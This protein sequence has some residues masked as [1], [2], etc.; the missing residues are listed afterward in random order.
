MDEFIDAL[1]PILICLPL[2]QFSITLPSASSSSTATSIDHSDIYYIIV[3]NSLELIRL[4]YQSKIL[5]MISIAARCTLLLI[6]L[7]PLSFVAL[8]VC[9]VMS[10]CYH[11][12]SYMTMHLAQLQLTLSTHLEEMDF[13][14]RENDKKNKDISSKMNDDNNNN[15]DSNN[16]DNNDNNNNKDA[17]AIKKDIHNQSSIPD[18]DSVISA[19][20]FGEEPV[21]SSS[22]DHITGQTMNEDNLNDVDNNDNNDNIN[23]NN[24]D[25]HRILGRHAVR[26]NSNVIHSFF[27]M[28][29]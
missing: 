4:M 15:N 20:T 17:T 23:G 13:Q 2:A 12:F 22:N 27:D 21:L 3:P 14:Q 5:I 28:V 10:S 19:T 11:A 29:S 25:D 24:N 8:E 6:Q 1:L 16:N 18:D 9:G 7:S 26:T